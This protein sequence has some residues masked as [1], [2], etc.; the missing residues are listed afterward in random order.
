MLAT[1]NFHK[2]VLKLYCPASFKK[3]L[4]MKKILILILATAMASA[5]SFAGDEQTK[6]GDEQSKQGNGDR[7]ARMQQNLGLS[8][9]QVA[10]IRQIRDDGGGKEEMLEVLTDEQRAIMKQRRAEMKG[11]GRKGRRPAPAEDVQKSDTSDS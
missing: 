9:Q 8:D 11:K 3:W 2:A 4:P 1:G 10:Q 5:A 6:Q 7:M